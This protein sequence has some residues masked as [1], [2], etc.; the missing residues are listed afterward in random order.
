MLMNRLEQEN[1]SQGGS[2]QISRVEDLPSAVHLAA[3]V[4]EEGDIV[5]L[6]P[7]GTSYDAYQ[8]FEERGRHFRM[9]VTEIDT[10]Q[11][12]AI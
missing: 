5:L 6:S 7:G 10:D 9:L 3:A 2:L 4:A 8:D 1:K 11:R 12:K